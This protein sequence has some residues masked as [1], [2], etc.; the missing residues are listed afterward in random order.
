MFVKRII[1]YLDSN[2]RFFPDKKS[3]DSG[4]RLSHTA[5]ITVYCGDGRPFDSI[6]DGV[7]EAIDPNY[8]ILFDA[9]FLS[10]SSILGHGEKKQD[11]RM[12]FPNTHG[13]VNQTTIITSIADVNDLKAEL[14]FGK[15]RNRLNG[16]IA[17]HLAIY[18]GICVVDRLEGLLLYTRTILIAIFFP[19]PMLRFTK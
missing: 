17:Y 16:K 2:I 10:T 7:V 5:Y 1:I 13:N 12:V 8:Q 14:G 11:I 6:I 15:V 18:L 3:S 19:D 4:E 9:W